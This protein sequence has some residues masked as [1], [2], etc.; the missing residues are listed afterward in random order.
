MVSN[1]ERTMPLRNVAIAAIIALSTS[2]PLLAGMQVHARPV[3]LPYCRIHPFAPVCHV[4]PVPYCRI[5]PFAPVCHVRPVPVPYCR[6][7]PFAP[8]CHVRPV[9]VPYCRIHPFAPVCHARPILR[10]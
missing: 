9:P 4:R 2:G 6:I 8:V 7:H 3:P 10:H 1:K 5:H